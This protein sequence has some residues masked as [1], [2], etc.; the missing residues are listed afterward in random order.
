MI[1]VCPACGK[2]WGLECNGECQEPSITR[3]DPVLHEIS[4]WANEYVDKLE[5]ELS[6]DTCLCD[7][8]YREPKPEKGQE[9]ILGPRMRVRSHQH[10]E[11]PVHT[12]RGFIIGFFQWAIKEK[13]FGYIEIQRRNQ[14][15]L[16]DYTEAVDNQI[17]GDDTGEPLGLLNDKD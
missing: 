16:K 4:Q 12:K 2:A 5:T 17:R 8:I 13:D 15:L 6:E 9:E 10:P 11:C 14:E 1:P 7:W 3:H